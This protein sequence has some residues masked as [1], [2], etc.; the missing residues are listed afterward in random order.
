MTT[1]TE[2]GTSRGRGRAFT[3][4]ELLLVIAIISI[5]IALLLPAIQ[6]SREFAR[7][8]QCSKNL[9]QIGLALGNYASANRVFP[10]GVVNDT[11]PI[12]SVPQGYHWGW[13]ARILPFLERTTIYNHLNFRLGVYEPQNDTGRAHR[14]DTYLCPSDGLPGMT[15]YAGC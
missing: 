10:P 13:E 11:G 15:S 12:S 2:G 7:R 6:S 3:L 4:L 14:T 9:M 8:L 1:P 5:L